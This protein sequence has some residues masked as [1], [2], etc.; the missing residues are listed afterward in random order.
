[1]NEVRQAL[2]EDWAAFR[3][4]RLAALA[5]T[6]DAFGSTLREE[7]EHPEAEW[8]R[9]LTTSVVFLGSRDGKVQAIASAYPLDSDEV[10]LI[11]IWAHPDSRGT[12][13]AAETVGAVLDWAKG[14]TVTLWVGVQN[15]SAERFYT[16]LGFR[17]TGRTG[18]LPRDESI[19]EVEM[20]L[21][22]C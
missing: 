16:K 14:R 6:P 15:P 20:L 19:E 2:P 18:A 1:M 10:E 11:R 17:R 5:D 13:L 12:G 4:V 21:A 9:K 8:R 3:D 22:P 7:A